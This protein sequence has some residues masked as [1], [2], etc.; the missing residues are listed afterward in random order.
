LHH[1]ERGRQG[2]QGAEREQPPMTRFLYR[3]FVFF[4]SFIIVGLSLFSCISHNSA[5]DEVKWRQ[6][7]QSADASLLYAPHF[8]ED[9]FF[10]PWMPME[11]R[12]FFTFLQ[13]VFSKKGD[14]TDE[15]ERYRPNIV[16]DLKERIRSYPQGDFIVWIGHAAFL[17]RINGEYWVTDPMFSKR[18]LLPGRKTPPGI[19]IDDL[20][21][22]GG[23]INVIVSHNH[24]DHLDSNSMVALPDDSRVFAPRGLKG[25]IEAMNKKEVQEMDWWQSADCGN[26][27]TLICLPAQ[28]WSRRIFQ[29]RNTTLWASYLLV[30]PKLKIYFGGDSGY[31]I[32]YKEFG[33]R[34]PGIDYALLPVTAYQPRWFM[35]YAHVNVQESIA[36]FHD[37][38]AR[39]F[40]PH[41]WGTFPLGDEPV[42]Y[43]ILELRKTIKAQNLDPSKFIILDIGQILPIGG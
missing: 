17:I 22:L 3:G 20:K 33:R 43:S 24:Y 21:S 29:G 37:L 39:H 16:A 32:G 38:G 41:Q 28:H 19:T 2:L 26:G 11:E 6:E 12:G 42:G 31:F 5:F 7:V 34:F 27:V 40:I 9:T 4:I 30:T 1:E 25:Y 18:A 15:E 35:H 23:K 13:W 36:A 8:K 10:N 14:Y